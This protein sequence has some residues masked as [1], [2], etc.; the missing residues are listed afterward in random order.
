L[1]SPIPRRYAIGLWLTAGALAFL[2]C[3]YHLSATLVDGAF[4]PADH[5]SLYHARRILDSLRDPL[6]MYQF[7][8]RVHA[9]AGA[10]ITWPWAY[11]MLMALAARGLMAL[12]GA[13][14]PMSVLAF[15]APAW[16]FVNAALLLG[17][18]ARLRLSLPMRVFALLFFATSP[19]TQTLHRIGMLDH[20]YAEYSFVLAAVYLGLGWFGEPSSRRRAIALAVLLGAAPAFHNGL[21]VLQLPV[22][23]TLACLWVLKRPVDRGAAWAFALA[24]VAS[25][26]LFLLPSEPFRRGEFSYY[27]H[28]WFHLYVAACTASLC[29]LASSLRFSAASA[30]AACALAA[31]MA[32]P[33]LPQ[34]QQGR[35]FIFG[36]HPYLARI[37][38]FGSIPREIAEGRW[39]RLTL[40]YSPLLWLLPLGIGGLFW[41][42]RRDASAA[43]V[44]FLVQALT[45]SFLLLQTFRLHY[46]GSFA[47]VLPLC[48]LIDDLRERRPSLLAS[49]PRALAAAALGTAALVPGLLVLRGEYAPVSNLQYAA[50]R[51]VWPALNAACRRAPGVVLAEPNDGHFIRY[52]SECS[53]I[54][55]NFLTTPQ[56][57]DQVALSAAMMASSV[58]D[59]VRLAPHVRYILV[60]RADD[61][62]AP[63][64]CGLLCPENSGLRRELLT[65]DRPPPRLRLLWDVRVRRE[66]RSEPEVRL[67]E[68][69]PASSP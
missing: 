17:I 50:T 32:A 61:P 16:V 46:F 2:L 56:D 10:W 7:D 18:A 59:I 44:F 35:D 27:L 62:R 29:V 19:M 39:W 15:I 58:A 28:S 23:L 38:E 11:D 67:F 48:R 69:V 20:H 60:R 64:G 57:F 30:A 9:P 31:L 47:L 33:I 37:A 36:R 66:G 21:F 49:R 3:V 53:N 55:D 65:L 6:G 26:A 8:D 1:T 52:H 63:G 41:R 25:T 42:L 68:V 14:D 34:L 22:L 13:R 12:T 4:L 51:S 54:A 40:F 45:G 24:L 5:D 43:S